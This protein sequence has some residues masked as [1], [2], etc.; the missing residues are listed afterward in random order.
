MN[1]LKYNMQF[2]SLARYASSVV[3]EKSD[4]VYRF[5]VG[6]EIHLIIECTTAFLK[7]IM[8]NSHIQAYAQNMK[9]FKRLQQT[10]QEHDQGQYK[11]A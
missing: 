11:R 7:P 5:V 3:S 10:A 4:W 6:L 8:Y 1:V 9:D 2:I